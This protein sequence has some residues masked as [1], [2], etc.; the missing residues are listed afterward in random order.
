M[1]ILIIIHWACVFALNTQ[2][3]ALS[4]LF[5]MSIL[6]QCLF[7]H[8]EASLYKILTAYVTNTNSEPNLKQIPY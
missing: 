5:L 4:I 6:I 7:I 1:S 8:A 3:L 2:I